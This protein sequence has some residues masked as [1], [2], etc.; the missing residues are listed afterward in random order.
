VPV[1][2]WPKSG[3]A[4]LGV[5]ARKGIWP[6]EINKT[7]TEPD[8]VTHMEI[9]PHCLSV[10]KRALSFSDCVLVT[11]MMMMIINYN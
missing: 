11:L 7:V 8:V 4:L 10:V 9:A 2:T 6:M 1:E 5:G 3:S